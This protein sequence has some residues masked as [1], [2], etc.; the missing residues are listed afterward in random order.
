[1]HRSQRRQEA[2]AR[3]FREGVG[4]PQAE[5][6][7][8]SPPLTRHAVGRFMTQSPHSIGRDQVLEKAHAL[9]REHNIRHLPVLEAGKLA[10]ILSQRDLYFVESLGGVDPNVVKVEEAMSPDT[11]SVRPE[12]PVEEVV[13]EMADHKYGCAV[14]ID[15]TRVV[16]VF[17]TT[18][19]LRA[20]SELMGRGSSSR[21]L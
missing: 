3:L 11:Y 12:T 18:D 13:A 10:G 8:S 16:G 7:S 2:I 6:W 14:V 19:A 4:A 1:M 15:G 9:M 5:A 17:T 20:L 21:L